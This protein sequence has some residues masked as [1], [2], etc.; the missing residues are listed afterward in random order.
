MF[1]ALVFDIKG[2]VHQVV[3]RKNSVSL[4]LHMFCSFCGKMYGK[5]ILRIVALEI[6]LSTVTM[7][8]LTVHFLC[9]NFLPETT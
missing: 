7:L 5:K 3:P 4:F 1:R 8:L 6:N 2:T 9:N